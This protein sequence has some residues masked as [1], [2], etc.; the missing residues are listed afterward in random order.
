MSVNEIKAEFGEVVG[1]LLEYR[2]EAIPRGR[3]TKGQEQA[4]IS[5]GGWVETLLSADF[6]PKGTVLEQFHNHD[7]TSCDAVQISYPVGPQSGEL[8]LRVSQTMFVTTVSVFSRVPQA[9]WRLRNEEA[10][11]QFAGRLFNQ[12][13]RIKLRLETE[14]NGVLLG[15]QVMAENAIRAQLDWLDTLTWWLDGDSLGFSV[16]KRTGG[17]QSARTSADLEPNREWFSKFEQPRF[18]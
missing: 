11:A 15:R 18:R 9:A 7:A 8:E 14:R 17:D 13:P 5:A 2:Y 3:R 10:A 12:A 4:L 16:L 6:Q 1:Q